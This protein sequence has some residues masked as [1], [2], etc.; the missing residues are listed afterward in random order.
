MSNPKQQFK[1]YHIVY[2]ITNLVNQKIYIGCHSTNNINDGYF[3][4]G[5]MITKAIEKYGR[6]NFIKDI[7][8]TFDNYLDMFAKEKELVNEEFIKRSDVYNIVI[9]GNGGPNKGPVGKKRMSHL[10]TGE[11]IVV[12]TSAVQ[13]MLDAGYILNKGWSSTISR[14]WIHKESVKKMIELHELEKFKL[15]GWTLG[16]PKSPTLGKVWIHNP[17]TNEYSLCEKVDLE[18]K[19]SEG[20]IKKKLAGVQKGS[21]RINNGNRNIAIAPNELNEY[22]S[23]GWTKGVVSTVNYRKPKTK[24]KKWIN[25]NMIEKLICPI[26]LDSYLAAGWLRGRLG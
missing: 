5:W 16:L 13:K 9:G 26:D 23:Q 17:T 6:E 25:N 15:E 7:L 3:G 19:L 24:G 21:I 22:L 2:Q 18:S 8:F 4:S 1:K 12:H 10:T 14:I 11:R 20:W